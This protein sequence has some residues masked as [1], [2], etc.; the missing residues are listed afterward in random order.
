VREDRYQ[1]IEDIFT[2]I[3]KLSKSKKEAEQKD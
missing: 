1:S 3:R 2:E